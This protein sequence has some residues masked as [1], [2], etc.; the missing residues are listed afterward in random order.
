MFINEYWEILLNLL[1]KLH[2]LGC[3]EMSTGGDGIGIYNFSSISENEV[4]IGI[5]QV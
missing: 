3:E 2:W 4:F 1:R 5:A